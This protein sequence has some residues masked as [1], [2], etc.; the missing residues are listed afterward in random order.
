[1]KLT[2]TKN[3]A[4]YEATGILL[5]SSFEIYR[6]HVLIAAGALFA[7]NG[8][9]IFK[10]RLGQFQEPGVYEVLRRT[11][12]AV[13]LLKTGIMAGDEYPAAMLDESIFN[14]E[15]KT[16][17]NINSAEDIFFWDIIQVTMGQYPYKSIMAVRNATIGVVKLYYDQDK[18]NMIIL[19]DGI[20]TAAVM[21]FRQ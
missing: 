16:T 5:K 9:M 1:M 2:I 3:P 7:T 10:V 15:S 21:P 14:T 12:A 19:T 17:A 11:K 6:T 13:T 8:K 18:P 4:V 20:V